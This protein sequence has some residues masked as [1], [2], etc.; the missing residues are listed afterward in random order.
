M[1]EVMGMIRSRHRRKARAVNRCRI[2]ETVTTYLSTGQ[3]VRQDDVFDLCLGAGWIDRDGTGILADSLLRRRLFGLGETVTG[4]TNRLKAFRSLLYAYWS[5][6]L[7]E[8]TTSPEAVEGWKELRDWLKVRHSEISRSSSRKPT[9]FKMLAQHLH[10]LEENPCA[11][12]AKSLLHG[13]LDELQY[14]IDCLFIPTGSWIKTEAVMAQIAEAVKWQDEDFWTLLPQ[15]IKVATGDAGIRVTDGVTRLAIGK[16]VMRCARQNQHEP[17]EE[18][19]LLAIE[20][21]GNPWQ[22]QSAWDAYVRDE[23]D[24]PCSLSREMVNAWLKDKMIGEFFQDNRQ[25]ESRSKLWLRYSVFMQAISVASPWQNGTG[26]SLLARMGEFLVVVPQNE[27]MPIQVF[28]WQLLF[29]KGGAKL[30][31]KDSV[32]GAMCKKV[33]DQRKPILC[34]SQFGNFQ[35]ERTLRSFLFSKDT[36]RVFGSRK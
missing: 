28:P 18:L 10:L 21:I 22:Q 25:D 31:D 30:L 27:D 19:F 33:L 5:F 16:L 13:S 17:H 8:H 32:D 2:L 26:P 12:Y 23:G 3:V 24:N 14:A 15:L 9:W 6:P 36:G 35:C 20:R 7:H 11:R 34:L 1:T 29:S 4:R